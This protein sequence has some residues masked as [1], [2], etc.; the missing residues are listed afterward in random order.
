MANQ[1]ANI[2]LSIRLKNHKKLIMSLYAIERGNGTALYVQIAQV[3]EKEF[4]S[5]STPGDRLPPEH[6]LADRFGV[7]RHTLRR[8]VDELIANG[9][10]TRQ[11]G[12]GI[13]VANQLIDYQVCAGTRFTQTLTELGATSDSKVVRKMTIIA[14]LSVS[15]VLKILPEAPVL[16]IETLRRV[17][18][19]PFCVIS[20]FLP[21]TPYGASLPDYS[22]GSLHDLLIERF[23]RLRRTE[24]LVTAVMPQGDDAKN[25]GISYTRPILRVKSLNVLAEDGSPV[26]YSITRFRA[27]RVQ[28]RINL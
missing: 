12:V 28:L 5:H 7:N 1:Q 19:V 24:S 9:I 3:I 2:Q 11:R 13:F 17:E 15:K 10:L 21:L 8:A 22:G 14:P 25:L 16:W 23:G 20:H 27:D 26:E 6:E 18:G 4:I